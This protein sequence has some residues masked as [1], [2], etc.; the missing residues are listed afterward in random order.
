MKWGCC[1]NGG[2]RPAQQLVWG[3]AVVV[4]EARA[5][6]IGGGVGMV[7]MAWVD[8][9]IH[10][11]RVLEVRSDIPAPPVVAML[12]SVVAEWSSRGEPRFVDMLDALTRPCD[13]API[14]REEVKRPTSAIFSN[15]VTSI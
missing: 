2:A 12:V 5:V 1:R 6:V 11:A 3:A 13:G 15:A 4:E 8:R 9:R 10:S 14:A 7:I